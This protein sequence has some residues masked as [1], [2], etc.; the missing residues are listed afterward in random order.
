M[1][2]SM[3]CRDIEA[4]IVPMLQRYGTGLTVWSPL[5]G[6]FLSGKYSRENLKD[7][8][9]RRGAFDFPP[10]DLDQGFALIDKLQPIAQRHQ[11][12]IAQIAI[13]WVLANRAVTSVL[14][15]ATKLSQLE[16]NLGS[17]KIRFSDEE[18]REINA[19]TA[20]APRYPNWFDAMVSDKSMLA[21]MGKA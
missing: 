17:L 11:A 10:V 1:Y 6:G 16:D 20:L 19:A 21:A 18:M 8:A 9:N 13:A 4:D 5:S 14:V 2:Y 7:P 15:G 3:L 12:S